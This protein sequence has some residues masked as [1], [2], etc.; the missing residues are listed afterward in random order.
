MHTDGS[1][2]YLLYR[3]AGGTTTKLNKDAGGIHYI[4]GGGGGEF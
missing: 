2:M 4:W 1:G 3:A